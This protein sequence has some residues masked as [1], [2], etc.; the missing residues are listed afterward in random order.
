[1]FEPQYSNSRRML[2]KVAALG[3]LID[4][5]YDVYGTLDELEL[6]TDAVER[7]DVK[8]MDQLPNYMK[9]CYL[10]LFNSITEIAYEVLKEQGINIIPYLTK[11]WADL[12]KALLREAKWYYNGYTPSL[13]EYMDNAWMSIGI[14]VIVINLFFCVTNPITKEAIE[15]LSKYPHIIRCS[16]T[17]IRLADDLATSMVCQVKNEQINRDRRNTTS[18]MIFSG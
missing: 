16:A 4:D 15:S 11:L 1:M 5:I 7:M 14:P 13:E 12:C 9:V 6:F 17:I 3:T 8:A 18:K 2:T 10:A